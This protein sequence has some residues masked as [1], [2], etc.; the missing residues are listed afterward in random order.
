[1]LFIRLHFKGQSN[2]A[3]EQGLNKLLS[4]IGD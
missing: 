1:M 4:D 3:E 2:S